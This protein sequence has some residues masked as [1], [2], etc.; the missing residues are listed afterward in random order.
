MQP[1]YFPWSGYFN[2]IFKS[3][4][5]IF[6]DDAQFSKDSWHSKNFV[7]INKEK[8][9][10]KVP[11]IKSPLSTMI[12]DKLIN[13]KND[14]KSKQVKTI[15]QSY[16]K[17][18]FID[19]LNDLLVFFLKLKTNNL[20]EMNIEIIKFI[21]NKINIGNNFICSSK[22]NFQ[23]KKTHKIIKILNRLNAKEYISPI[24][25]KQYLKEDKFNELSEV[26]LVF[27][28]YDATKYNQMHLKK[29]TKNLSIIDVIAN[30]GWK[31]TEDY[32]KSNQ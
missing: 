14:W 17:H 16:S 9:S 15:L 1:H 7:I 11:T 20:S 31:N 10:I 18:K 2:L 8:Y 32:V 3:D 30:L 19:D 22:F 27:N 26:K 23:E 4:K 5:F 21:S 29:F 13:Q 24:G 12:R 25:A 6:L 28:D